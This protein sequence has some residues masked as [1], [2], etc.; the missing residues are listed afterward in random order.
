MV[1]WTLAS[2]SR[3]SIQSWA[4]DELAVVFDK[5][6]GDT[7]LVDLSAVGILELL[8]ISPHSLE[9][10]AQAL[11]GWFSESDPTKISEFISSTLLHLQDIG[12]VVDTSV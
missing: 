7:H 2:P 6:T 11:A 4:D 10:I 1:F 9:G 3:I 12:L 8:E 5:V